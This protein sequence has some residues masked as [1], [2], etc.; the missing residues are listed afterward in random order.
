MPY[1]KQKVS[2]FTRVRSTI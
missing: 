1:I 2:L